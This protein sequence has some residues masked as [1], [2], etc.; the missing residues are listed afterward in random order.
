MVN[1]A[2]P[3]WRQPGAARGFETYF[4]S[5]ARTE[6]ARRVEAMENEVVK[7]EIATEVAA[8]DP[9]SFIVHDMEQNQHL[10]ESSELAATMQ[11]SLAHM[12]PGP[13]RG[14]KQA[15]FRVLVTAFMPAVLVEIGFGTNAAE[16]RYLRDARRQRE[17]AS[18]IADATME[19]LAGYQRRVNAAG[20]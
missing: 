3:R 11:R 4:L 18:S 1:A 16:A 10:R 8:D 13:N 2:N 15:G 20:K 19:Y 6:D 17:I 9:L 12:H 14:V 7:Y 5:E